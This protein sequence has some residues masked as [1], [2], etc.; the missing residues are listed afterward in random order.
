MSEHKIHRI[1]N[2]KDLEVAKRMCKYEIE[3]SSHKMDASIAT[4]KS[5]L[6]A[7]VEA[8]VHQGARTLAFNAIAKILKK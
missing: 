3:I 8:Y 4:L 7:T 1:R 5:S 6:Q 2:F